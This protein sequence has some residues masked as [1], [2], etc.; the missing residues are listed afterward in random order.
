[1]LRH[2]PKIVGAPLAQIGL[3]RQRKN[4]THGVVVGAHDNTPFM[5]WRSN[6]ATALARILTNPLCHGSALPSATLAAH[7]SHQGTL[8]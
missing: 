5:R 3:R 8:P 6:G 7:R 1:M 4:P 2:C